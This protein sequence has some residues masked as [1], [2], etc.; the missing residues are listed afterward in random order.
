MEKL[1]VVVDDDK[2][3]TAGKKPK[4]DPTRNVPWDAEHGTEPYEKKERDASQ[5]ETRQEG[6]GSPFEE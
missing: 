1:A 2:T 6:G 4:D 5:A 3:K